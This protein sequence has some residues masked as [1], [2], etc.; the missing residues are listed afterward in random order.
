MIP[1]SVR[2][3]L[4]LPK[5]GQI[6]FVV[7]DLDKTLSYYRDTFGIGPWL[8]MDERPEPCIEDGKEIHPVLRIALAY[9]GAVQLELIQIIEGES[10]H[11][12]HIRESK[13]GVHH[14]GFMVGDIEKRLEACREAG[15]GILHQGTIR[16]TGFMVNYAYLDTVDLTGTV[17]EFVQW[18]L[19]PIRVPVNRLVHNMTCLIGSR[20]FFKGRVVK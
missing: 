19:G 9:V 1:D 6:G 14:L 18:R 17:I 2:K 13:S 20:T 12:R 3:R 7:A 8:L 5:V 11:L 15:I 16:E 4:R 10:F